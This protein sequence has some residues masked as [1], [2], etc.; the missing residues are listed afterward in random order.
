MKTFGNRITAYSKRILGARP[1]AVSHARGYTFFKRLVFAGYV[2]SFTTAIILSKGDPTIYRPASGTF[3]Y[4]TPAKPERKA[5]TL[6][7]NYLKE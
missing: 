4:H 1:P 6:L 5:L 2:A 3:T 7:N